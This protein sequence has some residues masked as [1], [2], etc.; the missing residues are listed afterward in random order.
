MNIELHNRL[1]TLKNKNSQDPNIGEYKKGF[2]D[3]VPPDKEN[4]KEI[5]VQGGDC[6]DLCDGCFK[7]TLRRIDEC[8][9]PYSP[10]PVININPLNKGPSKANSNSTVAWMLRNCIQ[11]KGP[12]GGIPLPFKITPGVNMPRPKCVSEAPKKKEI[13]TK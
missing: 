8:C 10:T 4:C 3:W 2:V 1:L 9:I 13:P 5:T 6:K 7:E 11:P 12:L